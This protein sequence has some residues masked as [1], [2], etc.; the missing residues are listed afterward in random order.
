MSAVPTTR[1]VAGHALSA[2]V[3][4]SKS[5]VGLGNVDNTADATKAVLSATK[6]ATARTIAGKSFDGTA[7]IS[8]AASD[9][10]AVPTTRTVAGHAL[11]ADVTISASD[12]GALAST[13]TPAQLG[14][15]ANA[16]GQTLILWTGSQASYDAIGTKNAS[17][18]YVVT[19]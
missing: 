18:V 15:V 14:A 3:T 11:S 17:T 4:I 8:I 7:N 12:V 19:A 6:L 16:S 2:D 9:V 1:T 13:T 5:D 10:G